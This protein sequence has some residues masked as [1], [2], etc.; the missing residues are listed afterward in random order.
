MD[1]K[2]IP[3]HIK[4]T[5]HSTSSSIIPKNIIQTFKTDQ[6]HEHIYK[7]IQTILRL[8]PEYDYYMITD[9]IGIELIKKYFDDRT[10]EAFMKL[11]VGAAKGDFLRYI[12][13]YI[14]G[15]VYLDL[16]SSISLKL[17]E[18]IPNDVDYIYF[19]KF[20]NNVG[21]IQWILITKTQENFILQMIKE[22]VNR[23]HNSEINIFIATGSILATDIIY[24]SLN[25]TNI[26]NIFNHTTIFERKTFFDDL[27][28]SNGL[29]HKIKGHFL[30][31]CLY[32]KHIHFRL[33][34]FNKDMVYVDEEKYNGLNSIYELPV[35]TSEIHNF[36]NK[37]TCSELYTKSKNILCHYIDEEKQFEKYNILVDCLLEQLCENEKIPQNIIN[38]ITEKTKIF[39][40]KLK[41]SI[42]NNI[43]NTYFLNE[44]IYFSFII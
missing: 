3:T 4:R 31:I 11:K 37:L 6:I 23:I 5:I 39:Q 1:Y 40:L 16:D 7:N 25:N 33:E 17:C 10:L 20:T 19:Y 41:E 21:I 22:M 15:G 13:L 14:Y 42:K 43:I 26:Y 38:E 35:K 28:K 27:N 29:N 24:N 32:T 34:G 18:F 36:V 2:T 9:E 12:A 8:N 30:D 44:N